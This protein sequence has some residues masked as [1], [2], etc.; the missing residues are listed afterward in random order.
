MTTVPTEPPSPTPLPSTANWG[1]PWRVVHVVQGADTLGKIAARNGVARPDVAA[2]NG[3]DDSSVLYR[4]RQVLTIPLSTADA[5][6]EASPVLTGTQETTE[7]AQELDLPG[8]AL[9]PTTT[10]TVPNGVLNLEWQWEQ[11]LE[12]GQYFAVLL[13]WEEQPGPCC[14]HF[15]SEATYA[16][17][18]DG[19]APGTFRWTVRV[20]ED[21]QDGQLQVLERFVTARGE[22][23]TLAWPGSEQ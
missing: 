19:Y 14:L 15:A 7:T 18:L 2:I 23:L 16:L 6:L 10:G 8:P 13:W 22:E 17:D 12:E 1:G 20:V 9:L 4:G 5:A 21:G 3:M 11:E